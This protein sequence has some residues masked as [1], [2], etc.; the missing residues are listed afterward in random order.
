[1]LAGFVSV[2]GHTPRRGFG[3]GFVFRLKVGR[4]KPARHHRSVFS[5]EQSQIVNGSSIMAD[6]SLAQ[7]AEAQARSTIDSLAQAI[8]IKDAAAVTATRLGIWFSSISRHHCT[9]GSKSNVWF[10]ET[11]GLRR[12]GGA[13]KIAR[14][15]ESV[16]MSMDGS[17]RAAID[18]KR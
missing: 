16:P 15:H 13:W 1:M 7:S 17:F 5:E 4:Q 9:D 14:S 8:R 10:R 2:D 18:L 12:A 11:L 6:Q 3:A